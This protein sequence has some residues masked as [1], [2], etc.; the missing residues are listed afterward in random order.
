[1]NDQQTFWDLGH[2]TE[3][4]ALPAFQERPY[5]KDARLAVQEAFQTQDSVIIEM[6]TGLVKTEVVTQLMDQWEDGRCLFIA[7]RIELI[8]QAASKIAMRT[9]EMPG[10]E[11]A[12][13]WSDETPWGRSPFVVASKDTLIS[14]DPKRYT[15]LRDVGLVVVDE[16]H[17]SITKAW[18]EVL[19]YYMGQGAKVLGVTATA[20]RHDQRAM[21]NI[22]ENCV[23]QYGIVQAI[24]DGWL[25]NAATD[26][27]QIES[28]DLSG[29]SSSGRPWGR[30]FVDHELA[31]RMEE[32]ETVAE[33]AEVTARETRG[34]KTAIYCASVE[35]ARLVAERLRDVHD[36][37]ADWVCSDTSRCTPEHRRKAIHS[38]KNPGGITH[39]CNVEILSLGW[40]Y[41][42]LAAIVMARP[43]RSLTLYTQI[44]GRGTR[45][46]PDV[47]DGIPDSTPE[48][49][50]AAIA[51]S[52]KPTFRMIDLVD[53]S[54]YHKIRTSPDVMSGIFSMEAVAIAKKLA[55][56]S[57]EKLELDELLVE[58]QKQAQAEAQERTRKENARVAAEIAYSKTR[59]D[60]FADAREG[61]IATARKGAR[62]TFGRYKGQL[63]KDVPTWYL[64]GCARGKP[65]ITA[66]WLKGAIKKEL[67]FRFEFGGE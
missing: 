66:P 13:L 10:V 67:G 25:V 53:A 51:A 22:Y 24:R 48:K 43:T 59:I 38:F 29:V 40:D 41:P 58:A 28:L 57:E 37:P 33:I 63:V 49:R 6:A 18:H 14:G 12:G 50:R 42:A 34:T 64:T 30:D 36:I 11:Q 9:G 61:D 2:R 5:Q 60:P 54:L 3:A 35:E 31:S 15:R 16:C 21:Y 56:E 52:A 19:S 27:I 23:Y 47:V 32:Y 8:G 17:L 55:V 4:P 65:M 46:L 26:C 7:P 1:M 20:R 45:V 44:F 39:L 62:F